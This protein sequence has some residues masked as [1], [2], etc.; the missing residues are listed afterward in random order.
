MER[1]APRAID[2]GPKPG[3]L[4]EMIALHGR[5]Y[6]AA[7]DFPLSFEAK[8]AAEA[9]AFLARYDK[10]RDLVLTVGLPDRLIATLTL[11]SSDPALEPG[12]T[13]LRW[14][15]VDEAARGMGLGRRLVETALDFA[16]GSGARSMYL[17]TFRE[18]EAAGALYRHAGFRVKSETAGSTWGRTVTEQRLHLAL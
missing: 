11:D 5:Y 14:F 6:A 1:A 2:R 4:G 18:L 7:W 12:E 3:W 17:S 10:A 15:I 13:H 8:V 9:A 16:R